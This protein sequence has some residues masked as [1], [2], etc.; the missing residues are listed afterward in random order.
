ML[1]VIVYTFTFSSMFLAAM[2]TKNEVVASIT[3]KLKFERW[4]IIMIFL[5]AIIFGIRYNVGVDYDSYK[6]IYEQQDVERLEFIFKGI[7]IFLYNS[8]FH[9]TFYFALWAMGQIYFLLKSF[10]NEKYILPALIFVLFTGQYFLLWMNVIRQDLAACIFIY[11]VAFIADRNFFKFLLCIILA[12][13]FHKTAIILVLIY[14]ILRYRNNLLNNRVIQLILLVISAFIGF[15]TNI[16]INVIESYFEPFVLLFDYESYSS[17]GVEDTVEEVGINLVVIAGLLIDFFLIIYSNKIK[18]YY[19]NNKFIFYYDLY[20]GG[21]C[22]NLIFV[23]SYILLR[24]IRYFRFFKL[25]L[26]AYLLYYLFKNGQSR[27]NVA[28]FITLIMIHLFLYY[29]IFRAPKEACYIFHFID[30]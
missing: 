30:F 27:I 7:T 15:R 4:D 13:G 9:V 18:E 14:P 25:I 21:T 28:A 12:I 19:N 23:K 20:F 8:G 6:E 1:S 26:S 24:P 16:I 29:T 5:F 11:S 17:M 10:Q 2:S 3:T 22:L